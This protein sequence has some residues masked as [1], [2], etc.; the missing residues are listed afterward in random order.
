MTGHQ[1]DEC[2]FLQ[3]HHSS[4]EVMQDFP[5]SAWQYAKLRKELRE[6]TL[7]ILQQ[8]GYFATNGTSDDFNTFC[9]QVEINAQSLEKEK[10]ERHRAWIENNPRD[11]REQQER[12]NNR[13]RGGRGRG[14]GGYGRGRGNNPYYNTNYNNLPYNTNANF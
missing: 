1:F 12:N 14:N 2:A 8:T 9:K 7:I 13:G 4:G 5:I 3:R 6:H 10:A 11:Y